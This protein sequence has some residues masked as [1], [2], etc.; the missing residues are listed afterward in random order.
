MNYRTRDRYRTQFCFIAPGSMLDRYAIASRTH[1]VLPQVT[2]EQY[3]EF[4]RRKRMEGDF[5]ILDNGAYEGMTDFTG[6]CEAIEY[7]K[8]HVT[9]LPDF[10]LQDGE[11]TFDAADEFLNLYDG[12]KT[13]FMYI[14]QAVPGDVQGFKAWM[15]KAIKILR[16][17]WIGIPRA[18]VTHIAQGPNAKFARIDL[19][20]EL[21]MRGV[22]THALGMANGDLWELD[23]LAWEGVVSCDSSAPIWRGVN[24]YYMSDTEEWDKKGTPVDFDFKGEEPLYV[25]GGS[26]VMENINSVLVA[27]GKEPFRGA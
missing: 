8:P 10:L 2:N 22:K 15:N 24:G 9:A 3:R 4:Y 27:C 17:E 12:P 1:L 6:L 5:I 26:R 23:R 13:K 7:Y 19:V 11:K 21:N 25:R 20:E 18:L 16:V 14:P